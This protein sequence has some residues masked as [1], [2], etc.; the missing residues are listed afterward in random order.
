ME[1][2]AS[3][4]P[5]LGS[6]CS[7]STTSL[8]APRRLCGPRVLRSKQSHHSTSE[9]LWLPRFDPTVAAGMIMDVHSSFSAVSS[10]PAHQHDSPTHG[11]RRHRKVATNKRLRSL[12]RRVGCLHSRQRLF[13]S[14]GQAR[15]FFLGRHHVTIE[16]QCPS[17]VG[18]RLRFFE[19]DRQIF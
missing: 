5:A 15:N 10:D 19:F 1:I 9:P 4:R 18:V 17:A 12:I 11:Q 7:E 6:Q 3:V 16:P 13:P 2:S 8:K 14:F